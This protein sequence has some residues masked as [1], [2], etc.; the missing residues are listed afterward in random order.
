[1]ANILLNIVTAIYAIGYIATFIFLTFFDGYT[2]N[3]WNW[4]VAIPINTVLSIMWPLYWVMIKP[5]FGH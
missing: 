3:W 4:L 1:M 2:Y 5:I